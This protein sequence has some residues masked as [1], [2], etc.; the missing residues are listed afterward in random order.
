MEK[1]NGAGCDQAGIEALCMKPDTLWSERVQTA[2]LWHTLV[3][4]SA[5][6]AGALVFW[7]VL[8]RAAGRTRR[9]YE[10]L[11]SLAE[12]SRE[13]ESEL[14]TAQRRLTALRLVVNAT[15]YFLAI[16]TFI[17]VLQQLG[18]RFDSLLLPAGFLG[19]ALGLGAQNLVRDV[20]SG[21]FLLFEGQFGVGDIVAINGT[22]GTVEEVGLRVTRLRDDSG[23]VFFFPNGAITS[24]SKYPHRTLPLLLW[25]PLSPGADV[26]AVDL[27]VRDV[28]K[29]LNQHFINTTGETRLLAS[30]KHLATADS[31]SSI[32][33][34]ATLV[35]TPPVVSLADAGSPAGSSA[36]TPPSTTPTS[37]TPAT[38]VPIDWTCWRFTVHPARVATL[39][40]RVPGRLLSALN[41]AGVQTATGAAIEIIA[42]PA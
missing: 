20:V 14:A 3:S 34:E 21:L 5:I 27:I 10:T 36:S 26:P 7:W 4:V 8:A 13:A 40:E 41:A 28:I 19:A 2:A 31:S 16:S 24:V 29:V 33:Q 12:Q 30:S 42:A 18:I 6:V 9:H 23:Q 37:T 39:R 35:E 25:V 32:A 15:K 17:L 11:M 1:G 38:P 22:L